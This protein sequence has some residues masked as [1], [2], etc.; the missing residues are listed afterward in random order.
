MLWWAQHP[1]SMAE[2]LEIIRHCP[3]DPIELERKIEKAN[4]TAAALAAESQDLRRQSQEMHREKD[5]LAQRSKELE[6]DLA[7]QKALASLP[8]PTCEI[9]SAAL[10]GQRVSPNNTLDLFGGRLRV[11]VMPLPL[12][13]AAAA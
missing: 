7:S 9:D 10:K 12:A 4:A 2:R 3:R 11:S 1:L 5:A 13:Q 8:P 6:R